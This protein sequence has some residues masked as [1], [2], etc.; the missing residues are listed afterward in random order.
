MAEIS[1]ERELLDILHRLDETKQKKV[2]DFARDLSRPRGE[3]GKAFVE[4]TK[5][6]GFSKQDLAEIEQ[7]IEEGCEIIEDDIEINFDD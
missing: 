7:A 2:L 3:S 1:I 5:N 4:A 6:L